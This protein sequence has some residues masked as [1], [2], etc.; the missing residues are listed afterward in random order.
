MSVE[1]LALKIQNLTVNIYWYCPSEISDL[2]SIA[3]LW[4]R[5]REEAKLLARTV[6]NFGSGSGPKQTQSH[7]DKFTEIFRLLNLIESFVHSFLADLEA[8]RKFYEDQNG[9]K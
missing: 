5:R 1:F 3:V 7:V 9:N 2:R 6:I 8:E 4:S